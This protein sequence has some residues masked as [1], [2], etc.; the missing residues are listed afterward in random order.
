M[1]QVS[2]SCTRE[3]D[4]PIILPEMVSTMKVT[5]MHVEFEMLFVESETTEAQ[6]HCL[7]HAVS[8]RFHKVITALYS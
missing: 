3:L 5:G 7:D 1:S 4:L 8:S 2:F 6:H